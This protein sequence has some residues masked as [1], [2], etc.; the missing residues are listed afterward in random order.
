MELPGREKSGMNGVFVRGKGVPPGGRTPPYQG[1]R[2]LVSPQ[3]R[4]LSPESGACP[5]LLSD[6]NHS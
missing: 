6:S 5:G 2:C 4:G 1:V 3:V